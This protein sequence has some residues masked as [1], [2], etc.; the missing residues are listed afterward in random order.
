MKK[1]ISLVLVVAM[2]LGTLCGYA[3]ASTKLV[4]GMNALVVSSRASV[5][6]DT[7]IKSDR[8]VSLK[9]GEQMIVVGEKNGWYIV[10]RMSIGQGEGYGYILKRYVKLHPNYISLPKEVTLWADPWGTGLA[11]GSK[12]EGTI[13]LVLAETTEW[14]CVQTNDN[15]AGASFISKA[16]LYGGN[17]SSQNTAIDPYNRPKAV[18]VCSTLAVRRTPNDEAEPVGFFHNGDVLEIVTRGEYFTGVV[19]EFSGQKTECW[20]HTEHLQE[21]LE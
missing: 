6:V 15:A 12:S 16:E 17:F 4:S 20:V 2:L 8:I 18:V 11:N 21:L 10:D 5:R 3:S 1:V 7:D 19:W 9:N 13:L 14:L